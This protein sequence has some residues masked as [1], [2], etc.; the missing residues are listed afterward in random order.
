MDKEPD[1][2]HSNMDKHEKKYCP[3]CSKPFICRTGDIAKCQCYGLGIS[4]AA[5][6]FL[7][8]TNFDCLC[9][10]C[11]LEIDRLIKSSANYQFP[12][13]KEMFIEGVHYYKENGNWVFT[14]MYHLLRGY[15]CE[16]GCRHCMYGFKK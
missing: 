3:R 12:V 4:D 16:S 15:C 8:K 14:E 11:L 9:K 13:Q 6:D 1:I 2:L 10:D 5:R 7:L